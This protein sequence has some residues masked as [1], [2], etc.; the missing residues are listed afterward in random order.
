MKLLLVGEYRGAGLAAEVAGLFGFA[1]LLDAE[2]SMVLVG[3]EADLPAFEGRLWL[4]DVDT[5]GEYAPDR[6]KSLVLEAARREAPDAEVLLHSSYGW[7]LA[8]RVAAALNAALVSGVTGL[9][10]GGYVVECCNGKMRRT[11]RP[12][13]E[14]VV[15]TLQP[16]AFGQDALNGSPEIRY[17][18]ADAETS[19]EC[20]GFSRPETGIDLSHA[21][22]IVSAGR[23]IGS[24][25]HLG[26]VRALA[27]ALGAE[28]GASRP[29]VDAGWLERARQVGMS[30][31]NVSPGLYVACGISGSIQHLAGMKGSGFVLA[32]NTDSQAP[33]GNVA[34]VLVV[35]DLVD[36]LPLLT[37]QLASR[38]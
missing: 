22:A 12:L 36:F 31:Q 37:A 32:I 26:L 17:L 8:P 6:H 21:V 25:E 23:G 3:R 19:I 7:D 15:L 20:L 34:D 28:V 1:R 9:D 27:D 29:V 4:A 13:T 16:G 30:G 35:A 14:P 18:E 2:V 10:D 5:Y 38:C 11:V 24:K 33:I